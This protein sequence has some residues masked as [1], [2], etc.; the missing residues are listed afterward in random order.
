MYFAGQWSDQTFSIFRLPRNS[1]TARRVAASECSMHSIAV[2]GIGRE[3]AER[4][5]AELKR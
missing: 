2:D 5:L 4:Q 3:E 1:P